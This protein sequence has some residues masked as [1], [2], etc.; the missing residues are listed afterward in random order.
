LRLMAEDRH[1]YQ[2]FLEVTHL[3][4]APAAL[5]QPRILLGVVRQAVARHVRRQV[6]THRGGDRR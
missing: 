3:L 4:R 5:F 2:V 6:E 1:A